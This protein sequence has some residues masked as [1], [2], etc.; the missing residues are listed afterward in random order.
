MS[1]PL[2]SSQF[3]YSSGADDFYSH[4]INKS[5]RFDKASSTSLKFDL[6]SAGDRTSWA[7][8]TWLKF[9]LLNT[10][11]SGNNGSSTIF[12]SGRAGQ[13]DY[14]G[15]FQIDHHINWQDYLG[16]STPPYGHTVAKFRDTG[17]W[18][19]LVWVW[20]SDDSTQADR[21]RIYINGNRIS[22]YSASR[23]VGS[24]DQTDINNSGRDHV[25]GDSAVGD[26]KL[27]DGYLAETIFIDGGTELYTADN[28]GETK[29]GVWI[30]KDPSGLTFGSNGFHLK[31]EDAS[32]LGT[33]SSGN[34][35]NFTVNNA[36]TDHQSIDTP[37]HSE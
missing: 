14:I 16:G 8:S 31:Y 13:Y 4:Q 6:S 18:Y 33:D 11:D 28:F 9:G 30:P 35:N 34:G 37:T 22:D 15:F 19:H 32:N 36:G 23:A 21:S 17:G 1:G 7:F 27:F 20:D 10:S 24:G 25:I 2:G 5:M 26:G 12:G 3:M 29:N